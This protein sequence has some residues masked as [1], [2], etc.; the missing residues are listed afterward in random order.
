MMKKRFKCGFTLIE[1][2][3]V[4]AIIAVLI[5]LLLPS[6]QSARRMA[7]GI[8]CASN[9][10]QMVMGTHMYAVDNRDFFPGNDTTLPLY[11]FY[12]F[13]GNYQPGLINVRL[14]AYVPYSIFQCPTVTNQEYLIE[15]GI[16]RQDYISF[17]MNQYY[18]LANMGKVRTD[19]II[20]HEMPYLI[21]YAW[22]VPN[23]SWPYE[24]FGY[25]GQLANSAGLHNA[26][27]NWAFADGHVEQIRPNSLKNQS[28]RFAVTA[29][30]DRSYTMQD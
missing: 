28:D 10:K 1:L 9:Y 15:G 21:F 20:Y 6:L 19:A 25:N 26:V 16:Y 7:Q 24:L 17:R 3:V 29:E 2:L 5:A 8:K 12:N 30:S 4:V 11:Y 22:L 23:R 27:D 14:S 13:N 18:N